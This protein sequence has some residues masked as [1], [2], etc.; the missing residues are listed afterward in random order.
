IIADWIIRTQCHFKI[1]RKRKSKLGDY[2][3]PYKG[4]GHRISVNGDLNPFAFLITTVHEFA[5]LFTWQEHGT[6]VKPHGPAWKSN[7]R[8]LMTPF[9]EANIFPEDI[10]LA[11]EAYL[12]NPAASSC[13]DIYLSRVLHRYDDQ[14]L[15]QGYTF[16]ENIPDGTHFK[17]Q[18]GRLFQKSAKI[19]VRFRCREVATS[20]VYLF[21][22]VAAVLP[23]SNKVN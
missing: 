7:F 17:T 4:Q 1:A 10:R 22:P 6:T 18:D 19:R 3:A 11:I 2:R 23:L 21:S 16:L 15:R 13:G 14:H 12:K 8:A 5:H 9:F 20:R